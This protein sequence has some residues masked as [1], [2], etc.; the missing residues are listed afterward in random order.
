MA[1]GNME[2]VTMDPHKS[3]AHN[4]I[5]LKRKKMGITYFVS[6]IL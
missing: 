5:I 1:H 2:I 4:L 6:G 3:M